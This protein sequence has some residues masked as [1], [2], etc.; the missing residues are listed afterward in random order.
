MTRRVEKG[1]G[2]PGIY[3]CVK[4]NPGDKKPPRC[5]KHIPEGLPDHVASILTTKTSMTQRGNEMHFLMIKT[6]TISDNNMN[7]K[8]NREL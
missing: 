4:L 2:A 3:V 8:K 6:V 7:I 5:A 1:V